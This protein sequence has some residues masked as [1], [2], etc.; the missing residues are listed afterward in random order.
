MLSRNALRTIAVT[1]VVVGAISFAGVDIATS[2]ASG[3]LLA[4]EPCSEHATSATA[5]A[6]AIVGSLAL[7]IAVVPTLVWIARGFGARTDAEQVSSP[8]DS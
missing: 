6:L 1:C 7:L 4:E 8:S 5:M 3:C 2:S